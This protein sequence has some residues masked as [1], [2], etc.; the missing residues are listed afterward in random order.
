[1][2]PRLRR[3]RD[4]S[5]R[6]ARY[7]AVQPSSVVWLTVLWMILW[8]SVSWWMLFSGLVVAMLVSLAFPLPPVELGLRVRP[9]AFASLLGHFLVDIVRASFE[10][11]AVVLRRR[12]VR[13]SIVAVDL[14]SESDFVLTGVAAMLTLVPGS[15]VVEAYR[16]THTL[17]LHVLDAR[18]TEQ[19]EEFVRGA[20]ELEER[21]VRAWGL[22]K[23]EVR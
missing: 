14:R 18:T 12:P 20:H 22:E 21:F 11:S 7:R 5:L 17:Y 10:V 23:G 8:G 2:S 3:N 9:V 6:P 1:M 13:N 15:V 4:G 19:V 16:A